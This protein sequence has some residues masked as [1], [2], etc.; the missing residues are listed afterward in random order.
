V[1]MEAEKSQMSVVEWVLR[2]ACKLF[3]FGAGILGMGGLWIMVLPTVPHLLLTEAYAG[4]ACVAIACIALVFGVP[5][6]A[7]EMDKVL[8]RAFRL[9]P[10]PYR[11]NG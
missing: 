1:Q 8:L 4:V 3:S 2:L 11:N 10:C 7:V 6:M 5:V 9:K